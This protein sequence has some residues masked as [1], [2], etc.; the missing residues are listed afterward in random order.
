MTMA[1][2]CGHLIEAERGRVAALDVADE[3]PAVT[4]G[5]EV[6]ALA[7]RRFGEDSP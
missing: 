4:A 7:S 3:R 6:D 1:S 2:L 5:V